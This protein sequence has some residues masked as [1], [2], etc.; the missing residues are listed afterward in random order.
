MAVRARLRVYGAALLLSAASIGA[1]P[2][3]RVVTPAAIVRPSAPRR[4]AFDP[5]EQVAGFVMTVPLVIGSR[6]AWPA[7]T[8]SVQPN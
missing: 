5:V 3:L 8:D 7:P 2:E 4:G 6:S 1:L